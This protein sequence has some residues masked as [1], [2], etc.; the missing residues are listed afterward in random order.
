M[1][2]DLGWRVIFRPLYEVDHF[3]FDSFDPTPYFFPAK[4][5]HNTSNVRK[6]NLQFRKVQKVMT[7]YKHLVR[8][9]AIQQQESLFLFLISD[10]EF[11]LKHDSAFWV[12]TPFTRYN[13]TNSKSWIK[14][15]FDRLK[16]TLKKVK[17]WMY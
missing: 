10:F 15:M 16:L 11:M 3:T 6:H 2:Y 1:K 4:W 13:N 8:C 7:F 9:N 14:L 5:A 12:N 17:Y